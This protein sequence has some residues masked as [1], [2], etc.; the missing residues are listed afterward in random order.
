MAGYHHP[1]VRCEWLAVYLGQR[2]CEG[3]LCERCLCLS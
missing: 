1:G 3:M 2:C